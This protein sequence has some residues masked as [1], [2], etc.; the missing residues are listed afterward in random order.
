MP[1]DRARRINPTGVLPAAVSAVKTIY[2]EATG[3]VLPE[4]V[5]AG[6]RGQLDQIHKLADLIPETLHKPTELTAV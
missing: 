2:N 5:L 4:A 6:L 1:N 3:E